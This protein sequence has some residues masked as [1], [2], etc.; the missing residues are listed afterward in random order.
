VK[1][2]TPCLLHITTNAK[3]MSSIHLALYIHLV[4]ST[5]GQARTIDP[6]WQPQLH[7][8]LGG[9][10]RKLGCEPI[11][12]GGVSDHVHLLLSFRETHIISDLTDDLKTAASD[13]VH[14]EIGD[15]DFAWQEGSG[16]FGVSFS[17]LPTV[18]RYISD[19]EEYH[20]TRSYEDEFRELV[21]HAEVEFDARYLE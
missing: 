10:A 13:W 9:V 21:A 6:A 5:K 7:E 11:A 18:S 2:L 12:V 20:R 16:A 1:F 3:P 19:Q 4:F 15:P 14:A 8:H 17:Q